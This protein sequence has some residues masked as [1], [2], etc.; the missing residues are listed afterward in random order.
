MSSNVGGRFQ[1]FR[2]RRFAPLFVAQALGA[3][4]D[5]VFRN[6]LVILITYRLAQQQGWD[7]S[8]LVALAGGVFI[9]PFFLFS[10]HAG[11]LADRMDKAAIARAVKLAEIGIAVLAAI[12]LWLEWVPLML[13]VLFLAGTQSAYFGPVKY[14]ILPQHMADDE[15]VDANAFIEIATFFAILLGTLFG[16]LLILTQAGL[17]IVSITMIVLATLGWLAAKR[18]PPA[19]PAQPAAEASKKTPGII[20]ATVRLIGIVTPHRKLLGGVLAISWFWMLGAVLLAVLPPFTRTYLGGN[21]HVAN[22][23]I[24]LFTVGI[25]IGSLSASRLLKGAISVRF[26]PL[27][28]LLM[29]FALFDLWLASRGLRPVD[30]IGGLRT[31]GAFLSSWQGLRITVDF[32]LVSAFGGLFVVPFYAFVQHLAPAAERARVI[33]ANNVLNALFMVAGQFALAAMLK[34]GLALPNIFLLLATANGMVAIYIAWRMPRA[35]LRSIGTILFR[36]LYRVEVKGLEHLRDVGERAVVVANH[37]SWLDGP[38]LASFLPQDT[39]YAVHTA[40][41]ERPVVR[42]LSRI[43]HLLPIDPANPMAIRTLIHAV[44]ENRKVVI[45]PEG[46]ISTTGGLMK[47]YEGPGL[48]AHKADAPI[49]PVFIRGAERARFFSRQPHRQRLRLFPK[50]TITIQPPVRMNAPEG[51]A[52]PRL[53]KY[54][55]DKLYDVMAAAAFRSQPWRRHLMEAIIDVKRDHGGKH[56]VVEDIQRKPL[57]MNRLLAGCYILGGKLA[58]M[59][60]G[61]KTIGVLLPTSA[62]CLVTLLGLLGRGRTPAMLN[63]STGAVNMAAACKAARVKTI[64]TSRRFIEQGG[65]EDMLEVLSRQARIIWLEDVRESIGARDKLGG[66]LLAKLNRSGL[67]L[68]GANMDADDAAVILFTSGSEGVPKGVVLSH[69][70]VLANAYQVLSI[71]DLNAAD[72]VFNALPMFHALG[73]SAGVFLPLVAG[74]RLFLYPSPLHYKI[75]PELVYDTDATVFFGTDTFLNGY[76]RNAHPYDFYNVRYVVAGAERVKEQTRQEW[77]E[78]FG[79]RIYE[80]YGATETSPVLSVNTPMH[81]RSGSVGRLLPDVA[82]RIDPV[83]GIEEGGRLV[84]KGPNVM[85]GYLRADTPGVIEPPKDGWYDTGDIV[86]IDEEGFVT[87]KGRAKRFAKIG[88]EMVSLTA[89][90]NAIAGAFPDFDHAVV[91]V[92]DRKKGEKL[93]LI[94]TAPDLNRRRLAK[95]LK[96][97]GAPEL[98]VPRDIIVVEELPVL[99]SGKTDY[100]TLQNMARAQAA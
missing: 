65:L 24:A 19:P 37:V 41:A 35:F 93:V 21:E 55:A 11:E 84:V 2:T 44:E 98:W 59:T 67:K 86:T 6:A 26:A 29:T 97:R 27:S 42:L 49:V 12:S 64:V 90:E 76:A 100:V 72:R 54:L 16:G 87:I 78:K 71:I 36:L 81:F 45:F 57:S 89:V 23:F 94:T 48:I 34:S 20:S 88:G 58:A 4:N 99:G 95:A 69:A 60:P 62:A 10:G 7:V 47:I 30:G 31:L 40:E 9:L 3:F 8:T 77:M 91:S 50:I 46:R 83:E 14:A 38:A 17:S 39:A 13:L 52:G 75:I 28:A 18:I 56:K 92:P 96:E 85:K 80:G 79:L 1:L 53:R 70:N 68:A 33:A 22:F 61:E 25:A 82:H 5:N 66:L 43:F 32:V 63:F 73:L 74:A 15:L 51:V